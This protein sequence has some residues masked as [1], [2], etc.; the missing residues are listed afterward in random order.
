MF[1]RPASA[2]FSWA[3]WIAGRGISHER[4][5]LERPVEM[6][7]PE[8]SVSRRT[9]SCAPADRVRTSVQARR[10]AGELVMDCDL[11][12]SLSA[13]AAQHQQHQK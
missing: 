6:N 8:V 10:L 3:I 4:N 1:G 13:E 12:I 2:A 9:L 11:A 5:V 7:V